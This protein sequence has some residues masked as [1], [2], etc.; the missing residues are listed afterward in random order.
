MRQKFSSWLDLREGEGSLFS[1]MALHAMMYGAGQSFFY[2]AATAI[3]LAQF[4]DIALLWSYIAIAGA[5]VVVSTLLSIIQKWLS[6]NFLFRSI[7]LLMVVTALSFW[8][9][10]RFM[11]A[12]W[13]VFVLMAW[14]RIEYTLTRLEWLGVQGDV[15]TIQQGKRM[16][17]PI[18]SIEMIG[19]IGA[20]VLMPFIL[21]VVQ[22]R[23]L[24]LIATIC[25]A[26]IYVLLNRILRIQAQTTADKAA[27]P[28]VEVVPNTKSNQNYVWSILLSVGL[29]IALQM[30]MSYG[31]FS[32]LQ[33]RY[34][35]EERLAQFVSM[36]YLVIYSTVFVIRG[37]LTQSLLRRFGVGFGFSFLPVIIVIAGITC[38]AI[39]YSIGMRSLYFFAAITLT[40]GLFDTINTAFHGTSMVLLLQVLTQ[41]EQV[42]AK[43][44]AQTIFTPLAIGASGALLLFLRRFNLTNPLIAF[45]IAC[46]IGLLM[47]VLA[48]IVLRYYRQALKDNFDSLRFTGQNLSIN[49]AETINF[50]R[51]KL[52]SP[53]PIEVEATLGLLKEVSYQ[54]TRQEVQQLIAHQNTDIRAIGVTLIGNANYTDMQQQLM[55]VVHGAP[56]ANLLRAA[57]MAL[58]QL[59][60]PQAIEIVSQFLTDGNQEIREGAMLALL[61]YGGLDGVQ[62]AA[63]KMLEFVNSADA[64]DRQMVVK[65][66]A[67]SGIEAYSTSIFPKLLEDP[68]FDVRRAALLA[69]GKLNAERYIPYVLDAMTDVK[70]AGVATKSLSVLGKAAINPT[71]VMLEDPLTPAGCKYRLAQV[72]GSNNQPEVNDYLVEILPESA[73]DVRRT[74]YIVLTR[75]HYVPTPDA[76]K[77]LLEQFEAE[78][79]NGTFLAAMLNATQTTANQLPLFSALEQSAKDIREHL[80]RIIGLLNASESILPA[81][82]SLEHGQP[83]QQAIALEFFETL[84][85]RQYRKQTTYLLDLQLSHEERW[86]KLKRTFP[87]FDAGYTE[88]L[89]QLINASHTT[90]S[91][92]V[93]ACALNAVRTEDLA[94]LQ[95]EIERNQTAADQLIQET[96]HNTMRVLNLK[97]AA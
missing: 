19:K 86:D 91:Q 80:I 38:V 59:E 78:L 44:K 92:W 3:F 43:I 81:K 67:E 17:G 16:L 46:L 62:K 77:Y 55:D 49:N 75:N 96:A 53:H 63:R 39:G 61:Q 9:G 10:L 40:F 50:L 69:V 33:L 88:A 79:E 36:Y 95:P 97:A 18:G 11:P 25:F 32:S 73:V 51:S 28:V 14:E 6:S 54:P 35:S 26:I 57:F 21:A 60:T 42:Q 64:A 37:P 72:L 94:L 47:I 93:R 4:D 24:L 48:R 76:S 87:Q 5:A 70:L 41:Q 89:K 74:I 30:T 65:T 83:T 13:M 84:I 8:I 20:Y 12:A 56:E 90:V 45:S 58:C 66:I 31:F 82:H 52:H 22:T 34:P 71:K 1:L 27:A 2:T 68:D 15:L 7:I 23:D 85:P 29:L